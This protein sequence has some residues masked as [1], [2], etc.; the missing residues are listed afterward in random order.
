M[1]GSVVVVDL[2]GGGNVVVLCL[3]NYCCYFGDFF[4]C[5]SYVVGVVVRS[6][7]GVGI[8][9]FLGFREIC[10]IVVV[11]GGVVLL[12]WILVWVVFYI[13]CC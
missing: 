11:L 13:G 1:V 12:F 7:R 2:I 4:W 9:W 10:I 3:K 8:V 6:C 5:R